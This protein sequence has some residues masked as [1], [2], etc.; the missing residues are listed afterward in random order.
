MNSFELARSIGRAA[1]RSR[2]CARVDKQLSPNPRTVPS[3]GIP[4]IG[5][6]LYARSNDD[7]T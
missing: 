2:S 5:F 7:L 6:T 1:L 3:W 4:Y